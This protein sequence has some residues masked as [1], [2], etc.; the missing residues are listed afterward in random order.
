MKKITFILSC[1]LLISAYSYGGN[2]WFN[3]YVL[4]NKNATVSEYYWI[5]A[6][7]SYGTQLDTHNFGV[8]SS[9]VITGCDMKYWADGGDNRTGGAFYYKI[10]S[11]DNS[12]EVVAPVETIWNHASIGGNDYQGI[13]T[14]LSINL[15]SGLASNTTYNL[16]VW[17][18]SWGAGG[19]GW[20]SNSGSNYVA[21]FTTD[22]PTSVS[23][24]SEVE[25]TIFVERNLVK[26][27]FSGSARV[28]LYSAT[29]QQLKSVVANN[30][31]SETLRSGIYILRINGE[32][33]KVLV[34]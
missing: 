33:H 34:K 18:K 29:G 24:R 7:P 19:D 4:I 22:N 8:V 14:G 10:M 1:V 3:D 30:E 16:H 23:S 5:G 11:A 31:F 32:S 20:L 27:T 15:L 17:A 26:A 9:L 25:P 2:G 28:E 12:T 21:T 13:L 6:N